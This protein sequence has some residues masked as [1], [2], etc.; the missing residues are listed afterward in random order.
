MLL[1]NIRD[2]RLRLSQQIGSQ[3]HQ[4]DIAHATGIHPVLYGRYENNQVRRPDLDNLEKLLRYYQESGL[5]VDGR[6]VSVGD[7]FATGE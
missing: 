3:L 7:L 5:M 4:T 2:L 6:P 1:L